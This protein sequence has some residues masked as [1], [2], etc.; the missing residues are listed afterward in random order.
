MIYN[1]L[2]RRYE[3]HIVEELRDAVDW[4]KMTEDEA[5]LLF[6]KLMEEWEAEYGDYMYDLKG[7]RQL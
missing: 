5:N 2:Q 3:N 4:G 7:D 6:D 1:W